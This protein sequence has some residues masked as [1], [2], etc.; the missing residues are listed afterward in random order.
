MLSLWRRVRPLGDCAT[1]L[2]DR[3][4]AVAAVGGVRPDGVDDD[5]LSAVEVSASPMMEVSSG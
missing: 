1:R 5:A 2:R 4:C 3:D